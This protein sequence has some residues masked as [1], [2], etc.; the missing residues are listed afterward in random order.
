MGNNITKKL[1]YYPKES[2]IVGYK[3][4]L[5]AM[6]WIANWIRARRSMPNVQNSLRFEPNGPNVANVELDH[7]ARAKVKPFRKSLTEDWAVA[8]AYLAPDIDDRYTSYKDNPSLQTRIHERTHIMSANSPQL[9]YI[10]KLKGAT[11]Y[12]DRNFTSWLKDITTST[13]GYKSFQEYLDDPTEIYSRLME[14]RYDNN[15]DPKKI[16]TLKDIK[17]LRKNVKDHRIFSRYS[18]EFILKLFNEVA[19]NNNNQDNITLYAKYGT[20]LK[21]RPFLGKYK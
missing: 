14:L 8:Y 19:Q 21:R 11:D 17:E 5:P 4:E 2:I 6:R 16:W 12:L 9:D 15:I 10:Q 20:K 13:K 7:M 18:D 1:G 3:S